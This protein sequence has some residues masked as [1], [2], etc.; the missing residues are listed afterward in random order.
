MNIEELREYCLTLP[1]TEECF[2]FDDETL[3]FK[4]GGKMY[5][6][7]PLEKPDACIILKCDPDLAVELREKYPVVQPGNHMNKKYWNTV[8]LAESIT[9]TQLKGW[10]RHSYDEVLKKLPPKERVK[11]QS[12]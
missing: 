11:Y 9:E 8:Y 4:V 6:Y 10:I 2:P 1:F 12:F 3:V 7:I 5:G